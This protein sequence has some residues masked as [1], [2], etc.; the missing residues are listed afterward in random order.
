VSA[1]PVADPADPPQNGPRGAGNDE[2]TSP[3][4]VAGSPVTLQQNA[5]NAT[6]GTAGQGDPACQAFGTRNIN[7]DEW[8]LWVANASGVATLRSCGGGSI[9]TKAAV[10][11]GAACPPSSIV[12]CN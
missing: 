6:T 1:E 12:A 9:D 4:F 2:C 7:N 5:S 11:D 3:I 10:W 8:F